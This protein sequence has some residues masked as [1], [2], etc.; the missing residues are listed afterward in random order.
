MEK[1]AYEELY[2]PSPNI[3][4]GLDHDGSDEGI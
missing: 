2:Y 4:V 3:A 1:T